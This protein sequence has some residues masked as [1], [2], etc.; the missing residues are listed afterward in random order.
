MFQ[1]SQ[2][3]VNKMRFHAIGQAFF[4]NV[5][6]ENLSFFLLPYISSSLSLSLVRSRVSFA[7]YHSWSL[8]LPSFL[9][10]RSRLY[11]ACAAPRVSRVRVH[12]CCAKRDGVNETL[13]SLSLLFSYTYSLWSTRILAV[14]RV[15]R[16]LA[17]SLFILFK[18]LPLSL[19]H[20][21]SV[22]SRKLVQ[23]SSDRVYGKEKERRRDITC[24]RGT[25]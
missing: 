15:S 5:L 6:F 16:D 9:A 14:W 18:L 3:H 10:L 24:E 12:R 19:L 1:K 7:F 23:A 21:D 25:K 22:S 13:F 17:P 2:N 11:S 20:F 8:G 4:H